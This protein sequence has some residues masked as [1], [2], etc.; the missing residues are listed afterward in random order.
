MA[1]SNAR[2]NTF[3]QELK[4]RKVLRL[5]TVYVAVA[6]GLLELVDIISGPLN[7]PG[8]VL[9]FVISLSALGFPI[10]VILSWIF[11][12]TPDG[13]KRQ[14]DHFSNIHFDIYKDSSP[15]HSGQITETSFSEAFEGDKSYLPSKTYS[16]NPN[17]HK[18]RIFGVSSLLVII[19]VVLLFLFC[20]FLSCLYR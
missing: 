15:K 9:T 2:F 7:L 3:W 10:A 16:K 11:M 20:I 1:D 4:H 12:I 18:E 19:T 13:I 5:I 6:F 8:W 14:K 17:R